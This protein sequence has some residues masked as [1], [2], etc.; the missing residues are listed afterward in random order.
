MT[1]Q[2]KLEIRDMT[3]KAIAD[4]VKAQIANGAARKGFGADRHTAT[5]AKV[6]AEMLESYA[7]DGSP[8][9]IIRQTLRAKGALNGSQIRQMLERQGVLDKSETLTEEY[10][11]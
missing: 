8:A 7:D 1:D 2:K 9:E 10:D 6:A 5:L 11:V 4:V 3:L